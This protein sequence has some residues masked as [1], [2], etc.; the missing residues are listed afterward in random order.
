MNRLSIGWILPFTFLLACES[1]DSDSSKPKDDGTGGAG[2]EGICGGGEMVYYSACWG[3]LD[4][5]GEGGAD[6]GGE[7]EWGQNLVVVGAIE[8]RPGT[9]CD[10]GYPQFSFFGGHETVPFSAW[11]VEEEASGERWRIQFAVEGGSPDV[12]APGDV[13][14][15]VGGFGGDA[16][17]NEWGWIALERQGVPAIGFAKSMRPEF[18]G[19]P[20]FDFTP[21]HAM[22]RAE[23]NEDCHVVRAIDVTAN[24]DSAVI[25]TEESAEVGG[26]SFY[27]AGYVDNRQCDEPVLFTPESFWLA[28]HT[29]P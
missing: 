16:H 20:D 25:P 5:R 21:A 28:F 13:V 7:L 24:G 29:P 18:S 9:D 15:F 26:I 8:P 23:E 10:S 3:P 6:S 14:N 17:A 1:N 19:V 2:G 12:L 4:P 27:N 22:C 11:E